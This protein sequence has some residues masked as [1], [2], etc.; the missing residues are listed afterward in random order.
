MKI[1]KWNIQIWR[2]H[3][4][5]FLFHYQGKWNDGTQKRLYV[6]WWEINADSTVLNQNKEDETSRFNSIKPK[7]RR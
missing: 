4:F 5:S 1:G 3:G 6:L 2:S 7:Q